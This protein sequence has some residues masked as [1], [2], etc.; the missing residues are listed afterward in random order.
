MRTTDHTYELTQPLRNCGSNRQLQEKP[1]KPRRG[2]KYIK[3]KKKKY[4]HKKHYKIAKG[5]PSTLYWLSSL[6][7]VLQQVVFVLL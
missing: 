7:A 2:E 3:K 1:G 4:M 5:C 6:Q